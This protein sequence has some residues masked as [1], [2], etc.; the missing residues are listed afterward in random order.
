MKVTFNLSKNSFAVFKTQESPSSLISRP[1]G[2]KEDS[3][4]EV[5]DSLSKTLLTPLK[6]CLK[7]VALTRTK[8]K[9]KKRKKKATSHIFYVL[10]CIRDKK[11]F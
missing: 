8:K 1:H 6:S 10:E 11:S 2:P 5:T 3:M 9:P 4:K 7:E